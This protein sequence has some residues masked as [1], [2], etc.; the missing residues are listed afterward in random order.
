MG[1]IANLDSGKK[2]QEKDCRK[3]AGN[4]VLVFSMV[5]YG[6]IYNM[7]YCEI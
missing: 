3:H 5:V 4:L 6:T 7:V 1:D 2:T